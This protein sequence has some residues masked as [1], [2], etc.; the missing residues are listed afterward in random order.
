[1]YRIS[2]D[3]YH[4]LHCLDTVRRGL[5]PHYYHPDM[6]LPYTYRMHIDHCIDYLRQGIT[7]NSDLTP[8]AYLWEDNQ[9]GFFP[10]FGMTRTCRNF[11]KIQD[12]SRKR[13]PNDEEHQSWVAEWGS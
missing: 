2:L 8:L 3:V 9:D 12:W 10:L 11:E 4:S 6:K 7:C 5:D 1:M 13:I